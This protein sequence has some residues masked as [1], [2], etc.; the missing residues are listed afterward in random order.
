MA[1]TPNYSFERKERE[2]LKAAKKAE[3]QAAKAAAKER[4][5]TETESETETVSAED[6]NERPHPG[7]DQGRPPLRPSV[8]R[9]AARRA[10][11]VARSMRN[12]V[13]RIGCGSFFC[14]RRRR[15]APARPREAGKALSA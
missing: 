12:S 7:A 4:A 3:K 6:E 1:R 11:V 15:R 2:R 10:A 14:G 8:G 13:A 9:P 5:A